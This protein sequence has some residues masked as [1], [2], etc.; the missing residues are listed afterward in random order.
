VHILCP[1][2]NLDGVFDITFFKLNTFREFKVFDLFDLFN[3]SSNSNL[4]KYDFKSE[5]RI[6]GR[7]TFLIDPK[8]FGVV[9]YSF[10]FILDV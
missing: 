8:V 5:I 10:L 6:S 4:E 1:A 7:R 3:C 2:V 9:T